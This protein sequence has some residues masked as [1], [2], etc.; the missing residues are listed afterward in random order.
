[1]DLGM[2]ACTQDSYRERGNLMEWT[3]TKL[4]VLKI[5]LYLYYATLEC[6]QGLFHIALQHVVERHMG[7]RS[8]KKNN[9]LSRSIPHNLT[10][11]LLV[12]TGTHFSLYLFHHYLGGGGIPFI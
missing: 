8:H 6:L 1:M 11:Q 9:S 5:N 12:D 2:A 3:V 10:L 7:F 4:F